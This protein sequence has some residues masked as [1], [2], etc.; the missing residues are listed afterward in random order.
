[1]PD[2]PFLPPEQ[3]SPHEIATTAT[4]D[5]PTVCGWWKGRD[6]DW[7]SRLNLIPP[8][9]SETSL[10]QQRE[11]DKN[12]LW[13]ALCDAKS[14]LSIDP[15]P[16]SQPPL[17]AVLNFVA[18]GPA[19]LMLAP[20][21]DLLGLAEQPNLPGTID[22]HPNWLQ[23]LPVGVGRLFDDDQ[24]QRCVTAITQGREAS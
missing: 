8:E 1:M 6:L 16:P 15:E 12:L 18:R 10:R 22:G 20:L 13:Q 7:R 17:E 23:R 5:L 21:E 4:H 3:W 11:R 19:P 2:Q 9:D 24:V 14:V